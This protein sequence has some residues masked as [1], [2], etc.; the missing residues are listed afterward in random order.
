MQ[1]WRAWK[2][3]GAA[4]VAGACVFLDGCAVPAT[5]TEMAM[6]PD[7]QAAVADVVLEAPLPPTTLVAAPAPEPAPAP[8]VYPTAPEQWFQPSGLNA[9][10]EGL[11]R[12]LAALAIRDNPPLY[13]SEQ[14]GR[15]TGGEQ[16]DH[17]ISRNDSWAVD[18]A[19]R[20]IQAPTPQ[21]HL[22]A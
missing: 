5:R 20:G 21:T 6:V 4:L 19:V 12:F 13:V 11:A 18:V 16:S 22:A 1:N 14:W 9:G 10:T 7:Q 8:F 2:R 3:L 15:T 17:H